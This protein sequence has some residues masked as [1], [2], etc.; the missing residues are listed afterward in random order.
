[1]REAPYFT[2]LNLQVTKIET[3]SRKETTVKILD[4]MTKKA[5]ANPGYKV[6]EGYKLAHKEDNIVDYRVP[7]NIPIS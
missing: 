1:M 4:E 7:L 3:T 2:K 6:P 5:T